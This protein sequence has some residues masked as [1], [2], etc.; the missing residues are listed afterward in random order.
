MERTFY[1]PCYF[2][3]EDYRPSWTGNATYATVTIRGVFSTRE[4]AEAAMK[5]WNTQGEYA[6]IREIDFNDEEED[7]YSPVIYKNDYEEE[8]N[9]EI[10]GFDIDYEDK[11]L[12][13]WVNNDYPDYNVDEIYDEEFSAVYDPNHWLGVT[14]Y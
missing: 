7:S 12:T 4:K 13:V 6:T 2:T 1:V 11:C 9:K 3:D 10:K 8:G 5:D 14:D